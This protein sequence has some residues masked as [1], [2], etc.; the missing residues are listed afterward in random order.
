MVCNSCL[1]V[2]R[3]RRAA[4]KTW[5]ANQQDVFREVVDEQRAKSII[6]MSNTITCK[7]EGQPLLLTWWTL[8]IFYT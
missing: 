6:K 4:A 7:S 1:I 2:Q 3:I 8:V 5:G